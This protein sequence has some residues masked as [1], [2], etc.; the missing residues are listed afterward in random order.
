M[1][2]V[3]GIGNDIT[4]INRFDNFELVERF[5]SAEELIIFNNLSIT[6]KN[7]F[8]ASRWSVKESFVK[9]TGNKKISFK[10]ISVLNDSNGKPYIKL[11]RPTCECKYFV[12]ISHENATVSTFVL[13]VK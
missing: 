4:T 8:A 13:V 10:S 12:T 6:R 3:F 1:N 7:T 11:D 9:A 5:L 2:E